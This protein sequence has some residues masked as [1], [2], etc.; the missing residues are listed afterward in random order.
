MTTPLP[1]SRDEP[2]ESEN[3]PSPLF[4]LS[5]G[6][7]S[8][9]LHAA[10][11]V[12]SLRERFPDARFVAYGGPEMKKAGCEVPVLLTELAVMWFGRVLWNLRTFLGYLRDARRFFE[13]EKPD[14]VILID[15]PGFNWLIA[16]RAKA[17]G[18]PVCYFMPPQIWGWAQWR[19]KKMKRYIDLCLCTLP[20]E[21]KWL[22]THGV[23]AT[24]IGHPFFASV[25][26][27]RLDSV[28]VDSL[29]A[30]PRPILLV[31]PGSRNQEVSVNFA[32]MLDT[33]RRVTTA[34]ADV[35]PMI[36]AF[37]ESQ[38]E[39]I[40][41]QLR[42]A[43]LDYPV[44]VGRMAELMAA[45]ACA[46][47]VSGSVSM[48]LLARKK[49]TVIYYRL[50]RAAHIVMRR[51]RRVK[52]ITLVNLLAADANPDESIFYPESVKFIP[53][54]PTERERAVMLFPEFLVDSN[55]S[56]DAAAPLIEWL[57][58]PDALKKREREL[59]ELLERE[60]DGADPAA[61]AAAIIAERIENQPK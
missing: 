59:A 12:R 17:A 53:K 24:N 47:A 21:D 3:R 14:L 35:R 1:L 34:V 27:K 20:F 48:E 52:Y 4:F 28:F 57:T 40:R 58:N 41:G 25:R 16:R 50:G 30:D 7:P 45:C 26:S 43:G 9:D 15:F 55:R 6:E 18:I 46:L 5:A 23:N 33:V 42:R 38:A 22:H 8:G 29:R 36:G 2:K 56:A 51:F 49:P 11:L 32:D 60:D 44:Y 19:I 61:R 37:K 39:T 54:E 31:L 13:R 10:D